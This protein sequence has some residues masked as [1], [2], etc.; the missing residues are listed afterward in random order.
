MS[1]FLFLFIFVVCWF[2]FCVYWVSTLIYTRE[3]K[4]EGERETDKNG[5][6]EH[7]W[8]S[9]KEKRAFCLVWFFFQF[10]VMLL[11]CEFFA[12]FIQLLLI[13][14]A[15]IEFMLLLSILYVLQIFLHWWSNSF[16]FYDF[17]VEIYMYITFHWFGISI[18]YRWNEDQTFSQTNGS[19]LSFIFI[20]VFFDFA[21]IA[22]FRKILMWV[23]VCV[24]H[25][26]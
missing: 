23:S 8:N 5:K 19:F 1:L 7:K 24:C 9:Q 11:F 12:P 6:V 18:K 13:T 14:L 25:Q 2:S 10:L 16:S 26:Y 22:Y 20:L 17:G 4:R 3:K 21:I 15:L